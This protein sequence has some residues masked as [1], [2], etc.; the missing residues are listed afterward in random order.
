M[1]RALRQRLHN[2][3]RSQI[4]ND[5]PQFGYALVGGARGMRG[6]MRGNALVGGLAPLPINVQLHGEAKKLRQAMKLIDKIMPLDPEHEQEYAMI[7]NEIMDAVKSTQSEIR[8][9]TAASYRAKH[10]TGSAA[11]RKAKKAKKT[12]RASQSIDYPLVPYH[13]VID[14]DEP[15]PQYGQTPGQRKTYKARV[16]AAIKKG[17]PIPKY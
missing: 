9:N 4:E 14:L 5:A 13:E 6:G 1:N 3:Y 17:R 2:I 16:A 8:R 12:K 7:Y 10:K 15:E 11:P